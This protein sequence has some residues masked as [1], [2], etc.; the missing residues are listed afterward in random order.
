MH[1]AE[2]GHSLRGCEVWRLLVCRFEVG[3]RG[4]RVWRG[5]LGFGFGGSRELELLLFGPL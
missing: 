4:F 2:W 3:F 5:Y 1:R